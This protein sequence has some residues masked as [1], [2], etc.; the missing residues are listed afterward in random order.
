MKLR[1]FAVTAS[2]LGVLCCLTAAFFLLPDKAVS[3]SERRPLT[4]FQTYAEQ[5]QGAN[6]STSDYFSYLERYMLDQFPARD[7]FRSLKAMFKKYVLLQ[8]DNNGYY[9][10]DGTLSRM[11]GTMSD[12]AVSDA[13]DTL[14]R[15]YETYFSGSAAH[16][17]L[18]PDKNFFVAGKNGYLHYDYEKM[19]QSVREQLN[20][21]ITEIPLRDLLSIDDYYRTDPHW[22][23]KAIL[24]LAD[25]LL[26]AMGAEQLASEQVWSEHTLS[27]FYGAYYA[28]AALPMESDTLTYFTGDAL[29][30]VSV[31]DHS[32]K[33][34][35]GIYDDERFQNV[36]PY[37]VFLG[38]AVPLL[39]IRNP[40][41]ANGRQLVIFRDS[42][43]SSI[44]PLLVPAYSEVIVVDIR[45]LSPSLIGEMVS[46]QANCDV[47]F[48]YC[49]SVMNSYGIFSK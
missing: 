35:V 39:T 40:N 8:K 21:N 7:S 49:T 46:F 38:G 30:G 14:N 3:K 42:F 19:Y 2:F 32:A 27:P 31:Y 24:P 29:D 26:S 41:Q 45:Y 43:G 11:D 18:I 36:D 1:H 5:S 34:E 12:K 22:D 13:A 4:Q 6:Y 47:L 25:E 37:D 28:Q 10:A 20:E 23:Q 16:Y 33:Q 17:A 15:V 9:L 44:I 48:L